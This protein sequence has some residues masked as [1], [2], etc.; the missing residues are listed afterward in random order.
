M[1][2]LRFDLAWDRPSE[3]GF[4]LS[5]GTTRPCELDSP[6]AF[7]LDID[8]AFT[9]HGTAR[10]EIPSRET[11]ATFSQPSNVAVHAVVDAHGVDVAK[12][13]VHQYSPHLSKK[14]ST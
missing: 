1:P 12:G 11:S 10:I 7:D 9:Q 6:S 13:D 4:L 3:A 5:M 14:G 2:K 8:P